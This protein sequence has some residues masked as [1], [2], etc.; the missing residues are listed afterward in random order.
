M[1]KN[2][3]KIILHLD[4][5]KPQNKPE[6]IWITL[7]K[8]ALSTGRYILILVE[9]IVLGAFISRFKLD[10]DL[11]NNKD[12]IEQ[13]IPYIESLKP[14]E[15]QV[16][17]TQL[18]LS[19]L[20]DANRL[21]PDYPAI[22]RKIASQTPS[23]IKVTAL[24]LEKDAGSAKFQIVGQAV[25]NN[26]IIAFITGLRSDNLFSNVTLTGIGLEKDQITF[27]ILGKAA[28][29]ATGDKKT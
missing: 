25:S 12:A 11:A 3:N 8:W 6:Q 27:T 28:I 10:S 15:I 7:A 29:V 22:L 24:N 23:A 20:K 14:Y 17:N 26:D 2:P 21:S 18:K 5:L 1:P 16:R 4:L 19:T 9:I 13:Q